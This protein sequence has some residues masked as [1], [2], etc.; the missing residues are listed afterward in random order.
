MI[1][2]IPSTQSIPASEIE[3]VAVKVIGSAAGHNVDDRTVIAAILRRKIV[4]EN[5][6]LLGR[7]R[8]AGYQP[9]QAARY[10]SVIIIATVQQ[11]VV[12]AL[13]SAVHGDAAQSVGLG[14]SRS[15]QD[16]LIRIAQNQR[17]LG[18]LGVF[19]DVAQRGG[20]GVDGRHLG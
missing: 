1:E 20:L 6:E 11:K 17:E 12:I 3:K 5:A 18:H 14:D 2:V 10:I 4:R 7:I 9:P 8:V 19:N 16:Q 15:E 13:A